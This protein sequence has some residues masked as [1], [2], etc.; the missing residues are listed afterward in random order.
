MTITLK[1]NQKPCL[2]AIM[3]SWVNLLLY[4]IFFLSCIII[5]I[6]EQNNIKNIHIPQWLPVWNLLSHIG[7]FYSINMIDLW[8]LG[9]DLKVSS[10]TSFVLLS[11]NESLITQ[12]EE[13]VLV[14]VNE[15]KG[16]FNSIILYVTGNTRAN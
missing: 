9:C 5:S 14:F 13:Y 7:R 1:E 11:Y 6:S 12:H 15:N 2:R 8:Y 4:L 3:R 16:S 10:Q